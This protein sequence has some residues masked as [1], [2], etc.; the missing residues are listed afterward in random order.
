MSNYTRTTNFTAKDALASGNPSKVVLGSEHQAEYDAVATAVAT[1]L[2]SIETLSLETALATGDSIPLY[3][4]SATSNKRITVAN[5]RL[6]LSS[7]ATDGFSANS[8]AATSCPDNQYTRI[9]LGTEV[10]DPGNNFT[11][12]YYTVPV[13]GIY[14]I[15][16]HVTVSTTNAISSTV[17]AAIQFAD[18]AGVTTSTVTVSEQLITQAST[19]GPSGYFI[20]SLTAA[21]RFYLAGFQNNGGARDATATACWM[22]AWRLT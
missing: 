10:Y 19:P 7:W 16:A 3:D 6:A 14:I 2:D 18:S 20:G 22:S 4:T 9:T 1:K 5:A 8:L 17:E 12:N 21:T 11:S 13:T 15:F